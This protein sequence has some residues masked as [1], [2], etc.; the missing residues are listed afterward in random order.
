M[1]ETQLFRLTGTTDILEITSYHHHGQ[2][3]TYWEDIEEVF[4]GVKSIMNG[5][6]VVNKLR[7]SN[8][9]R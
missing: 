7:D 9:N 6:V 4:P 1:E 2:N 3:V 5:R 8:G